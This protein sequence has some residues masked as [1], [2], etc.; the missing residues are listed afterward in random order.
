MR[1]ISLK[2]H[3]DIIVFCQTTCTGVILVFCYM[4][5]VQQ[6]AGAAS[7]P[8]LWQIVQCMSCS[9]PLQ[10]WS[11]ISS[12]NRFDQMSNFQPGVWESKRPGP[13]LGWWAVG[14]LLLS[15]W[16]DTQYAGNLL[17]PFLVKISSKRIPECGKTFLNPSHD[18]VQ[19]CFHSLFN[20]WFNILTLLWR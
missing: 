12:N 9:A 5:C 19:Q 15:G 1:D 18:K 20:S 3:D 10:Y 13:G 14:C 8:F 2:Q 4:C 11:H 7:R 6:L 16:N 17:R